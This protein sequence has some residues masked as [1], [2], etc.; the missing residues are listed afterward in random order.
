MTI[1]PGP[2]PPNIPSIRQY[3][4]AL[5]VSMFSPSSNFFIGPATDR[6]VNHR[7]L[8]IGEPQRTRDIPSRRFERVRTNDQRRFLVVFKGNAVMH[9]AR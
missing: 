6:V 4:T 7:K 1:S 3:R 8:V 2:C 5:F 9:T